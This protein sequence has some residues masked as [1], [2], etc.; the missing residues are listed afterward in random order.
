MEE[1]PR[2]PVRPAFPQA[3]VFICILNT[4]WRVPWTE[5]F[6]DNFWGI[7]AEAIG[8]AVPKENELR[9]VSNTWSIHFCYCRSE[10]HSTTTNG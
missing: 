10:S 9:S 7:G 8:A 6:L 3:K 1:R 2:K 4:G 5:I